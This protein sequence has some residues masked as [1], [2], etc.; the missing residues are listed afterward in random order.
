M[1]LVCCRPVLTRWEKLRSRN[2]EEKR[3]RTW[4]SVLSENTFEAQKGLNDVIHES[5]IYF[6]SGDKFDIK[7]YHHVFLSA[8]PMGLDTLEEA[9]DEYIDSTLT[10]WT[11]ALLTR[12]SCC[13]V[14]H[15][16]AFRYT[17]IPLAID[18]KFIEFSFQFT[19]QGIKYPLDYQ[20][21]TFDILIF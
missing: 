17:T 14:D 4:V 13:A 9:V 11:Q 3:N 15:F 18:P 16:K 19:P 7:D 20:L 12:S 2:W 8:G 6:L 1:L 10:R 5:C 21:A